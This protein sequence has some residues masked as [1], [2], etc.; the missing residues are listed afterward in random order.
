MLY[1]LLCVGE[2]SEEVPVRKLRE[3]AVIASTAQVLINF[4]RRGWVRMED[5]SLIVFDE[6]HHAVK[7][8]PFALL[9]ENYYQA[10]AS[11]VKP[12]LLGL[13]ASPVGG[14]PVDMSYGLSELCQKANANVFMPC[15]YWE[16]LLGSVYRPQIAFI[17]VET[18]EDGCSMEAAIEAYCTA[19][20]RVVRDRLGIKSVIELPEVYDLNRTRALLRTLSAQAHTEKNEAAVDLLHH[21]QQIVSAHELNSIV[22]PRYARSYI[23][24]V[25]SYHKKEDNSNAV[26]TFLANISALDSLSA[27][28]AQLFRILH[29]IEPCEDTRAIVF[30]QRKRTAR[31]LCRV[32]EAELVLEEKWKPAVFV[33]QN[34]GQLD[35]MSWADH[36]S[37][38]LQKFRAGAHRLLISTSVL[39]EGIDVPMCDHIILFDQ[40]W[41][42]TSFIQ[43][44][45]RARA[46]DSHYILICNQEQKLAYENLMRGEEIMHSLI[47]RHMYDCQSYSPTM[48]LAAIYL[49]RQAAQAVN[50]TNQ[51]HVTRLGGAS[52]TSTD[53]KKTFKAIHLVFHNLP[54]GSPHL[55]LETFDFLRE[56]GLKNMSGHG[57]N[58]A[59]FPDKMAFAI[60][61]EPSMGSALRIFEVA[62]LLQKVSPLLNPLNS[63]VSFRVGIQNLNRS[64]EQFMFMGENLDL[65]ALVDF[66][67]FNCLSSLKM[68]LKIGLNMRL[69]AIQIFLVTLDQRVFRIDLDFGNIE[70]LILIDLDQEDQSTSIYVPLRGAAN[71]YFTHANPTVDIKLTTVDLFTWERASLREIKEFIDI[72]DISVFKIDVFLS[73]NLR[74]YLFSV[75]RRFDAYGLTVLFGKVVCHPNLPHMFDQHN[76]GQIAHMS[77][78]FKSV[79]DVLVLSSSCYPSLMYRTVAPRFMEIL[80]SVPEH[81]RHRVLLELC[82]ELLARPFADVI[83]TLN[84]IVADELHGHPTPEAVP[85]PFDSSVAGYDESS[86]TT[87]VRYVVLT[88]TRVVFQAPKSMTRNRIL[89]AFNPEY[90]LR[91]LFRDEDLQRLSS[92]KSGAGMKCIYNRIADF[93]TAGIIIGDR[94]YDFLAMSSSQLRDHG[95]WFV[96]PHYMDVAMEKGSSS[97]QLFV[98]A[99]YV[100]D[101]CGDFSSIKNVAKYVARLGQSLSASLN[102][103][104]V[105]NQEYDMIPDHEVMVTAVDGKQQKYIFTDGIGVISYSV[106]QEIAKT[107]ALKHVPTAYQ[108]RFA[109]FKGVLATDPHSNQKD[110]TRKI[111]FR[112]SMMKFSSIHQTLEVL[113]WSAYIPCYLNRQVLLILS[114]LGVPNESFTLLQDKMLKQMPEMLLDRK[115][116]SC[117]LSQ[118]FKILPRLPFIDISNWSFDN[119]PFFRSLLLAIY[120]RQ[121]VELLTRSRVFVPMGRIL[122]GTIDETGTLEE[123]EIFVQLSRQLPDDEAIQMGLLQSTNDDRFVVVAE[124]AIAKNPCMH[125]GDVRRLK[126]V[127]SELLERYHYDCVVFPRKGLRPITDMCS[128]SDLDGDLYFVT[129]DPSLLPPT[130]HPPMDYSAPAAKEV[131]KISLADVQEFLINFIANDQLGT[132]ANS[133][134][135]HADLLPE[136]VCAP[137]CMHLAY[138]FS[139]AVDFPKTGIIPTFP[140]EGKVSSWPD[141]MQK[142]SQTTHMSSKVMGTMFRKARSI[143]YSGVS[144]MVEES[145]LDESLL[146]EGHEAYLDSAALRYN[147]YSESLASTLK[148]YGLTSEAPVFTGSLIEMKAGVGKEDMKDIIEVPFCY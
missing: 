103:S 142:Y 7:A 133:H 87:L 27:K 116:A 131:E 55:Q 54:P 79:Y 86:N 51:D 119:E 82:L 145:R 136:G 80:A 97:Q 113:N 132:I 106:A 59:I 78:E 39:Q 130:L 83:S 68:P 125:P 5:A 138:I 104:Q 15:F 109:G 3:Y 124:V 29:E 8:H 57:E 43:S 31:H 147:A 111:Q 32:L 100:R 52:A 108:I 117:A 58:D 22:G 139:L 62:K 6:I 140:K 141:F 26:Q 118:G 46:K 144:Y 70:R 137:L 14:R 98:D 40:S 19:V 85:L 47:L 102:V 11:E 63:M 49:A 4:I 122:M 101:W 75:L 10:C 28:L 81:D 45:G 112:P 94:K 53:V 126:A 128:G 67:T 25:F 64:S 134:M 36:Q 42:L 99:N 20:M 148:L 127:R 115:G 121:L 13:T 76:C 95:C 1:P 84:S 114:S 73:N 143:F 92:V 110:D 9:I 89:R 91:V 17:V 90:F 146:V 71:Y 50:W 60:Q 123:D 38:A 41:T 77:Q 21:I 72:S 107:M 34:A 61:A 96:C 33:G 30:V 74:D 16:D 37:P 44:R 129:W 56:L 135:A 12:L 2:N 120:R 88:P 93:L 48:A 66:K 18:T 23:Q 105:S 35:G 69:G 65:G 24:D